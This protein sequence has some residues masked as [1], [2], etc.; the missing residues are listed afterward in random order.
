MVRCYKL[1]ETSATVDEEK[2]SAEKNLGAAYLRLANKQEDIE[3]V[4][5]LFPLSV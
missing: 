2:A 5:Q 1:A 4:Q 3:Q